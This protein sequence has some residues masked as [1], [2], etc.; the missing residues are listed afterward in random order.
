MTVR[1]H[2]EKKIIFWRCEG[3]HHR[4]KL[5]HLTTCLAKVFHPRKKLKDPTTFFGRYSSKAE[6]QQ[7]DVEMS[8]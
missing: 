5:K 8:V 6:G 7:E 2:M 4:K 1:D 3:L